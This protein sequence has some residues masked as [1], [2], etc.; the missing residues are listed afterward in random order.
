MRKSL[1]RYVVVD[2]AICHGRPTFQGTRI[3]VSDVLS[4]VAS[5]MEWEA[6]IK[7]WHGAVSKEAISEAVELASEALVD[8]GAGLVR[9][10]ASR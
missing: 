6:I 1:G 10:P 7:R 9:E 5:G 2:T 8:H 3:F 4:D